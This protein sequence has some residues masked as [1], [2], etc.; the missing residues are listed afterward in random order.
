MALVRCE[1]HGKPRGGNYVTSKLPAGHPNQCAAI[2]GREE[3]PNTGV[4]WLKAAEDKEYNN[5]VR[6]F[7]LPT[8][9]ARIRVK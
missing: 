6:I 2:C 5:G 8:C 4:V 9:A 7:N 3:C 1:Q